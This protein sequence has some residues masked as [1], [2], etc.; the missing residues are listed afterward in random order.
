MAMDKN[1]LIN[2]VLKLENIA[3]MSNEELID[4]YDAKLNFME[5]KFDAPVEKE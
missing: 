1:E 4:I 5:R 2:F 3:D